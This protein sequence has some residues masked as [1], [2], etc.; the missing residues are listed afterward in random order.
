MRVA[1]LIHETPEA[2]ATRSNGEDD[3]Y[4]GAWRLYY[5]RLVAAGVYA[6]GD[7]LDVPATGITVRNQHG[8]AQVQDGPF[9]ASKEQLAG[10]LLLE[11]DS[12][13]RALEWAVQCPAA[14]MGAVEVRPVAVETKE[15]IV[16]NA[17]P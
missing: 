15:R 12:V 7:A 8:R 13:Q 3:A 1:L 11:V 14:A 16:G 9:A 6:G 5:R 4:L 10:V 17:L 2:F